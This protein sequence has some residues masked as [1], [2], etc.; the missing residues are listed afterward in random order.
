ML[1][2]VSVMSRRSREQAQCRLAMMHNDTNVDDHG[3]HEHI[4]DDA[5]MGVVIMRRRTIKV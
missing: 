1:P 5:F 2:H 3:P 4:G